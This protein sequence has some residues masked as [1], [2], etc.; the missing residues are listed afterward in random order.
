MQPFLPLA[1]LGGSKGK[2]T[3][4]HFREARL[5]KPGSCACSDSVFLQSGCMLALANGAVEAY[6]LAKVDAGQIRGGIWL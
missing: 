5:D 3:L 4:P 6:H 2:H 1:W